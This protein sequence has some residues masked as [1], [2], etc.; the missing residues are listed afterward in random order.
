MFQSHLTRTGNN[1]NVTCISQNF[2]GF[3]FHPPCHI[4]TNI[5]KTN[6]KAKLIAGEPSYVL[7]LTLVVKSKNLAIPMFYSYWICLLSL[8]H[9][10]SY[11]VCHCTSY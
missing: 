6:S 3:E 5:L 7:V 10:L 11:I 8:H 1:R 2:C 9:L 4:N